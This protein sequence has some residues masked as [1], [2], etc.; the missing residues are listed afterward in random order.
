MATN[1]YITFFSQTNYKGFSQTFPITYKNSKYFVYNTN[2]TYADCIGIPAGSTPAQAKAIIEA[3]S[4]ECQTYICFNPSF[5]F[6]TKFS[7]LNKYLF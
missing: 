2:K 3:K 7:I 4:F 6:T 5:V 1:Y